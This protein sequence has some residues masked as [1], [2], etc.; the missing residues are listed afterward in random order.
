MTK[1]ILNNSLS[2]VFI[3]LKIH[4]LIYTSMGFVIQIEEQASVLVKGGWGGKNIH[5]VYNIHSYLA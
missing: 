1:T 3:L 2:D 5:S 4:M